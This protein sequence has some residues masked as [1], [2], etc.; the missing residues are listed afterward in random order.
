M[1][2]TQHTIESDSEEVIY[3]VDED[4]DDNFAD[5]HDEE[6]GDN[7]EESSPIPPKDTLMIMEFTDVFPK[8]TNLSPP[9]SPMWLWNVLMSF[10]KTK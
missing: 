5:V 7:L 2:G 6:L 3:Y 1:R 4:V 9:K 8:D 10:L